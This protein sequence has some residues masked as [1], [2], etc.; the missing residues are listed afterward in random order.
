[1]SPDN[2]LMRMYILSHGYIENDV[3]VNILNPNM[4]TVDDKNRRAQW[5][6]VP[7]LTFLLWHPEE[8]WILYDTSSH[9][10]AANR[11]PEWNLRFAPPT[12]PPD[13]TLPA[14][15]EQLGLK[16]SDIDWVIQ[17]HLHQDHAGGICFFANTKAGSRIVVHKAELER[18]LFNAFSGQ[19]D[20]KA[21]IREDFAGIPGIKYEPIY[22]EQ[23]F[24]EGIEMIHLPGHTPGVLGLVL[25]FKNSGTIILPS[26]ALYMAENFGPPPREPGIFDDSVAWRASVRKIAILKKKYKATI[27]YPHDW[28]QFTTEMKLAPDYYD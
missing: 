17:S 22:E 20:T 4:A 10:D 8:G 7:S 23:E 27:L 16:P 21:Y 12:I 5:H 13:E 24:A 6:R 1:M 9:P 14:R 28:K 15:L 2:R 26:D 11:W 3:A 19:E 18:A 25:H